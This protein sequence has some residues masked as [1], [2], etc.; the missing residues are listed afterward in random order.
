MPSPSFSQETWNHMEPQKVL[1]KDHCFQKGSY[2][3]LCENTGATRGVGLGRH[4][5]SH[6]SLGSLYGPLK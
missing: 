4:V 2:M 3:D 6:A 1:Y 5:A